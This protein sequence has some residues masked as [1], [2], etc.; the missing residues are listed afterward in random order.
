MTLLNAA[1]AAPSDDKRWRI[2]TAMMR[3]HGYEPHALIETL[4]SV[5]EAFGFIDEAAMHFVAQNLQVPLSKVYGVAT[6]YN[7]FMLKPQGEHSCVVCLGTACYIKG[8][9][10]ILDAIEQA[11][12]L[13]PGETTHDKK[14]SLLVARC[15]GACGLAPA[16]VFDGEVIGGLQPAQALTKIEEWAEL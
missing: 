14:V 8:A 10:A 2:V 9:P 6:F 3:R 1:S 15:L 4:H 11:A 5:Q 13:K 7:Y 16:A 12:H